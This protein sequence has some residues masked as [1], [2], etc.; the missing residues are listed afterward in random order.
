VTLTELVRMLKA[1]ATEVSKLAEAARV[2]RAVRATRT[3]QASSVGDD[4][5]SAA[6]RA[7]VARRSAGAALASLDSKPT[8][9]LRADGS[10]PDAPRRQ[11]DRSRGGGTGGSADQGA[12]PIVAEGLAIWRDGL[13]KRQAARLH[14]QRYQPDWGAQSSLVQT[15]RVNALA[16][17]L[18]AQV[19]LEPRGR[20]GRT[21]VDDGSER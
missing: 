6:A 16:R 3:A 15:K 10:G 18:R 14:L 13:T 12:S 7:R 21:R 11:G 4:E 19:K 5:R 2:D 20:Q 17:R 1:Q 9:A 8:V